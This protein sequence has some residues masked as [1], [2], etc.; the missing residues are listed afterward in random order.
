MIEAAE[1]G[2]ALIV[3]RMPLRRAQLVRFLEDWAEN[4]GLS[5]ADSGIAEI[6]TLRRTRPCRIQILSISAEDVGD[7]QITAATRVLASACPGAPIVILGQTADV[8]ATSFALRVGAVSF[9]PANLNADVALAALDFVLKGGTY[10]PIN[11]L[12]AIS[13]WPQGAIRTHLPRRIAPPRRERNSELEED[14][15]D[16]PDGGGDRTRRYSRH[17]LAPGSTGSRHVAIGMVIRQPAGGAAVSVQGAEAPP[18]AE[19]S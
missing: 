14:G 17:H 16:E 1:D 19:P 9:I 10:F 2:L 11:A 13:E 3:D 15:D 18:P 12:R 7:E 4:R 8:K 6:S 5:L